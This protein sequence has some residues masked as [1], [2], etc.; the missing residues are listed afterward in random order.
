M[1]FDKCLDTF[2]ENNHT[3]LQMPYKTQHRYQN[4]I[5]APHLSL[6]FRWQFQQARDQDAAFRYNV[7]LFKKPPFAWTYTSL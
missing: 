5:Q 2:L 3:F 7:K 4:R 1:C 6:F